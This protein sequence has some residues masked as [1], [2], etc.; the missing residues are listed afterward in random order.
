[1]Q[2]CHRSMRCPR[3]E[4]LAAEVKQGRFLTLVDLGDNKRKKRIKK[5]KR[6]GRYSAQAGASSFGVATAACA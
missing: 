6:A 2:E 5:R 3:A 1:M 4:L